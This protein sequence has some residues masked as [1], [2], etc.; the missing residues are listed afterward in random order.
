MVPRWRLRPAAEADREL[1]FRVRRDTM[2]EYVD[3]TWGWDDAWQREHFDRTF[4]PAALSVIVVD[5]CDAGVLEAEVRASVV[6]L[7]NIQILPAFQ[8]R[9]VGAAVVSDVVDRAGREG[10]TVELQVLKV[11]PARRFYERL[12][13]TVVGDT[14]THWRMVASA[15]S[16]EP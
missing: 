6:Y 7:A 15:P 12:G 4:D 11:N 1:L 10:Q 5:G 16:T 8:S 13:F 2:R 9:G 3:R 14:A